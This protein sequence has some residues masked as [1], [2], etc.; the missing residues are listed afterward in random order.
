M[1]SPI[2]A[3]M[4]SVKSTE[5][6]IAPGEASNNERSVWRSCCT[7]ARYPR[8]MSRIS[9]SESFSPTCTLPVKVKGSCSSLR[10]ETLPA[11]LL[12]CRL[13][14]ARP[15]ARGINQRILHVSHCQGDSPS[16]LRPSRMIT[17]LLR[18]SVPF[19]QNSWLMLGGLVRLVGPLP[20]HQL[21]AGL[22]VRHNQVPAE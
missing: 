4:A 1:D 19:A 11:S 12:Q 17:A 6:T 15:A 22:L 13:H 2:R 14:A 18:P 5:A 21:V 16:R 3:W 9:M 10:H 7:S 20:A 8:F